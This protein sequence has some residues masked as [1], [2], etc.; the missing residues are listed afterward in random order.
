MR[1]IRARY[2][3]PRRNN[4]IHRKGESILTRFLI[5]N[6]LF[7]VGTVELLIAIENHGLFR[8]ETYCEG[9]SWGFGVV[10]RAIRACWN[11]VHYYLQFHKI[12]FLR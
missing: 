1:I 4:I 2:V 12:G 9:S 10:E 7:I 11:H 3:I 6:P 5:K 8:Y